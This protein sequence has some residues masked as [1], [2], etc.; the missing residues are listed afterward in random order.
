MKK[1]VFA[2]GLNLPSVEGFEAVDFTDNRALLEA[3]I[4]AIEP[5]LW[6]FGTEGRYEGTPKLTEHDSF[7]FRK[8]RQGWR[9]KLLSALEAG[10]T[11]VVFL[12]ERADRFYYTG[13]TQNRGTPGRPRM[14]SIVSACSNYDLLPLPLDSVEFGRGTSMVLSSSASSLS[15]YWKEFGGRSAYNCHFNVAGGQPLILT[16]S[17]GNTVGA[18]L[19]RLGK[20]VYLP[21]ID[22]GDIPDTVTV[23]AEKAVNEAGEEEA[24]EA[25]ETEETEEWSPGILQFTRR[26]RDA[27]FELD[28]RLGK[29][30]EI[31]VAPEWVEADEYRLEG[32]AEIERQIL[33]V[34]AQLTELTETRDELNRSLAK[35]AGIRRLLYEGGHPLEDAVREALT[36]LGFDA[37]NF[38]DDDSEFDALF[39]APEGR[40]L[41][42]VEGKENKAINV[43]KISQLHRNVAEDMARD[44]VTEPAVPVLFGNAFRLK[45]LEERGDFFT[46]KVA[47]FAATSRTALVRTPDLF[48]VARHARKAGDEVFARLCREAIRDGA[49]T[50]VQFPDVPKVAPTEPAS[51]KP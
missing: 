5:H 17:G 44:D 27:L 24:A 26:L 13:E 14:T 48:A 43:D 30:D 38:K 47:K 36:A 4:I 39:T 19:P 7:E 31:T 46:E 29:D 35:E 25:E 50:I 20:L 2:F 21:E 9:P 23:P 12:T 11:V 16:R 34:E 32:E 22:W 3:D 18:A 33:E 45:P 10:K 51:G 41:G 40:F 42:E 15:A 28:A 1:T 8:L 37:A 49:G 6:D